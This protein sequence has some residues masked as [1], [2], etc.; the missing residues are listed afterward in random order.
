MA[1]QFTA[2]A[3]GQPGAAGGAN[4]AQNPLI[5]SGAGRPLA[6]IEMDPELE[7]ELEI[8]VARE[9]GIDANGR[10]LIAGQHIGV[11]NLAARSTV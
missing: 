1:S 6:E 8:A 4:S 10:M 7:K 9:E 5:N 11:S 2:G 3:T